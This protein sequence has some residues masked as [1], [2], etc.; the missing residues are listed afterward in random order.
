MPLDGYLAE[1]YLGNPLS[2]WLIALGVL[3]GTFAVLVVAR[4]LIVRRLGAF[5]R[6]TK[7][8]FDDL[9][10][11]LARLTRYFFLLVLSADAAA[12]VLTPS[13]RAAGILRAVTVVAV[14]L[15]VA[16]WGNGIIG[17]F[18]DRYV[19]QRADGAATTT[20]VAL[21]WFGRLT[22]WAVLLLLAL[23]NFGV[24]ITALVAGL[25]IGGIAVALAVQNVLGDLFGAV[26]I[27]LD[28]PFVVGDFIV[29]DEYQGSVEHVGLKTTRLRS[30]SGEQIIIAN[31]DLLRSR[32]RNFKRMFERRVQFTLGLEYDTPPE[33]LERVPTLVREIVEAQ[34]LVRFE[35]SH[36]AALA[37]SSVTVETVYWVTVSDYT[38]YMDIQQAINLQLLRRLEAEGVRL[39]FPTRTILLADG[40]SPLADRPTDGNRA[41]APE[42]E[43]NTVGPRL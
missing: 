9:A 14:L 1:R 21:G 36:V 38:R 35:R 5:V 4:L 25:G 30:L 33:R 40:H 41:A 7:T 6:R 37:E 27:V 10:V 42:R 34:Q 24:D 28:R 11:D 43:P 3:A 31:A 26:S 29:V 8:D 2:D 13:P 20:L 23:R 39:A 15:Q 32:I 16:L 17:F 18:V 22:L 12:L 19:R